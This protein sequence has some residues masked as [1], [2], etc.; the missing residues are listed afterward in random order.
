MWQA[1][2]LGVYKTA[3]SVLKSPC[4]EALP[5]FSSTHAHTMH[6]STR[7]LTKKPPSTAPILS[8]IGK[9]QMCLQK[10]RP[11]FSFRIFAYK[12]STKSIAKDLPTSPEHQQSL[13]FSLR[14]QMYHHSQARSTY[15]LVF[16]EICLWRKKEEHRFCS[17]LHFSLCPVPSIHK[18]RNRL[19]KWF[20]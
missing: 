6:S 3:S 10:L 8:F 18:G 7:F 16:V 2:F 14:H 4:P 12:G 9:S 5:W 17:S 1:L 19:V 20:P 15:L 13:F 11:G